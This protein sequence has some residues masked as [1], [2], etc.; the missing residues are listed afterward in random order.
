[1]KKP[2]GNQMAFLSL[3]LLSLKIEGEAEVNH[4]TTVE[5]VMTIMIK[6]VTVKEHKK[7]DKHLV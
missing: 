4:L 3:R 6:V 7:E 2:I 5:K 1:M